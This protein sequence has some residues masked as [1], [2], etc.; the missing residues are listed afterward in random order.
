MPQIMTPKQEK[1]CLIYRETGNASEAALRAGLEWRVKPTEF[2][3]YF[4]IDDGKIF[5]VGKGKND[6]VYSHRKQLNNPNATNQVK[7]AKIRSALADG[8]FGELIFCDGLD[9]LDAYRLEK[10]LIKAFKP[11]LTN[12]SNGVTH[13][14]ESLMARIDLCVSKIKPFEEWNRTSSQSVKEFAKRTHGGMKETYDWM[15]SLFAEDRNFA[16][17]QLTKVKG[18][19][20]AHK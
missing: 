4:L 18:C 16:D 15:I 5:Y 8:C 9:E 19:N 1:F 2:Y 12:I 3:V 10:S 6:R 20:N 14:L 17:K 13:P 7:L 11:E